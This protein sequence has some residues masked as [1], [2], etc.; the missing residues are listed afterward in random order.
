[1][2]FLNEPNTLHRIRKKWDKCCPKKSFNLYTKSTQNPTKYIKIRNYSA[3]KNRN[4]HINY[5]RERP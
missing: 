5:L 1:M 3:I 4:F 2:K